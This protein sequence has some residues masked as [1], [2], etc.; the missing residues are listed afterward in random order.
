VNDEVKDTL[1]TWP[2]VQLKTFFVDGI[3][4]LVD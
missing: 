1:N 3:G 4:K 2:H